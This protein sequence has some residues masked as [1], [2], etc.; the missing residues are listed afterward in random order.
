MAK[1]T[2]GDLYL[3]EIVSSEI[4]DGFTNDTI[5]AQDADIDFELVGKKGNT[6]TML[7]WNKINKAKITGENETVVP[8]KLSHSEV[9]AHIV[10]LADAVSYTGMSETQGEGDNY[11]YSVRSL[12]NSMSEAVDDLILQEYLT[13]TENTI[14]VTGEAGD[15]AKIGYR[16]FL[17][18][19][20]K[21]DKNKNQEIHVYI[22]TDK[23]VDLYA[24]SSNEIVKAGEY[25]QGGIAPI[26]AA[27]E[28][29]KIGNLR[30]FQTD[31]LP[32]ESGT[33]TSLMVIPGAVKVSFQKDVT[34]KEAY[35]AL[36]DDNVL[37]AR[38]LLAVKLVNPGRLCVL[39]TK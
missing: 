37:V 1:T 35:D 12:R 17:R 23:V 36:N 34:I 33:Y 5:F 24:G 31:L 10:Q 30:I 28:V 21:L 29:G 3:P 6:V 38:S 2:T 8:Q 18:G 20:G 13:A 27:I 11:D 14:D 25:N 15:L 19:A 22:H 26:L 7:K 9:Q 32:V 39:K 4:K 16:T